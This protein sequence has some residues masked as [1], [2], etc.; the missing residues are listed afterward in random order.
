[1]LV[2]FV[3]LLSRRVAPSSLKETTDVLLGNMVFFFIPSGV[4]IVAHLDILRDDVF[5]LLAVCLV[6]TLLTFVAS[7]SAVAVAVRLQH[8]IQERH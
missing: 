7:F 4:R 5:A 8:K 1:M 2:L 3:L 6:T